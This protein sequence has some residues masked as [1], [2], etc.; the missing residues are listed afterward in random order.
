MKTDLTRTLD[1]YRATAGEFRIV[2]VPPQRYRRIDGHGD[3]N[4]SSA[5]ADALATLYPVAYA[6]KF[7]SKGTLDRD[8]VVPPLEA[9]WWA[10]DPAAFTTARDKSRWGWTAMML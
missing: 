3:P 8:Y 4:T 5:Y 6:L 7:A 1:A 9:L 2:E 10:D